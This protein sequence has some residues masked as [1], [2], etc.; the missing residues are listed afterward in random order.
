MNS[1]D[2]QVYIDRIKNGEI[3]AYAFLVNRYKDMA[4]SISLKIIR[5]PQE[6]EDATQESFIKAYESLGTFKGTSKFSTWL[7][8][9]VYRTSIQI[10]QGKKTTHLSIREEITDQ[11]QTDHEMSQL[12]Q[13]Q[14]N[15]R[16]RYI[17]KAINELHPTEAILVTLYYLNESPIKEISEITGLS[18]SN[19]KIQ[20]FRARKKLERKLSFLHQHYSK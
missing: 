18:R 19:I 16:S 12:E 9:I 14:T 4:Y 3:S 8:T 20:L 6:A 2:D 17:T 7:Y 11:L 1:T 5:N 15:E 10:I 13:L